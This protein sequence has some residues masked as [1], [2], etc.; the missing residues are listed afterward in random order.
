MTQI[1]LQHRLDPALVGVL[2]RG[3]PP[4]GLRPWEDIFVVSPS[5]PQPSAIPDL[6]PLQ[7]GQRHRER[8]LCLRHP[9]GWASSAVVSSG[10]GPNI[11]LP[12]VEPGA[13]S[14]KAPLSSG[15]E[16]GGFLGGNCFLSGGSQPSWATA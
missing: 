1:Q 15:S 3:A 14:G 8:S 6:A 12:E 13:V 2:G 16:L 5:P 11:C 10:P 7:G 4:H 9:G